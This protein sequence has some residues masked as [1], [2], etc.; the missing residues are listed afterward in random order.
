MGYS[1]ARSVFTNKRGRYSLWEK[2]SVIY[3]TVI[4]LL[5]FVPPLIRMMPLD[6]TVIKTFWLLD[7]ALI[8]S[9][10]LIVVAW[11]LLLAWSLSYR[12]K[13]FIHK[14]I[15]FKDNESLF[16]LFLLL[17][18]TTAYISIGDITMLLRNN[19]TYTLKLTNRYFLTSLVLLIG[20]LY[21]LRR[22][23]VHAKRLTKASIM[24]VQA[25]PDVQDDMNNFAQH[26]KEG[27]QGGLF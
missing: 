26:L 9:D 22:G 6:D 7:P 10:I 4:G 1:N 16:S 15:G 25:S 24:H 8:K 20:I 23:I 18:I 13:S 12:C 2:I 19:V 3:G 17:I 11:V 5:L 14:T 21:T 27:E